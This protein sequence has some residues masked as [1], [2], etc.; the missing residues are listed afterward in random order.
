MTHSFEVSL[1][2]SQQCVL[3]VLELNTLLDLAEKSHVTV[4]LNVCGFFG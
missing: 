4:A 3:Q 2:A 1:E